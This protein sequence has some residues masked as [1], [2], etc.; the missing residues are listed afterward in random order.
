MNKTQKK[1]KR[2][3]LK[4]ASLFCRL[5]KND[6]KFVYG[7][8]LIHYAG[9]V[10]DNKEVSKLVEAALD[11]WLTA[12]RFARQFE[13]DLEKILGIKSCML[14]NS[15]SSANLLA[16]C[17]LTSSKLGKRRLNPGDEIITTACCFPTTLAPIIQNNL[18]PVFI[19]VDLGTYNIQ[20]EKIERAI[21]KKTKGLFIAHALGNPANLSRIMEI[22]KRH[23]LWFIED[24]CDALGAKYNKKYTGTFGHLSTLSFY[25]AHHITMGEGGA[26][27]TDDI[28]LEKIVNSF[29]D[30]GRD[31]WCDSGKDNTC[32]M[33]FKW[34]AGKLPFGYDHKYIYSHIGYNLKLT[35]MQAAIGIEQ[36]KKLPFF[37]RKRKENFD[38]LY[39]GLKKYE[40]YLILPKWESL[41]SPSW[42]CFP[43]TIREKAGFT[44]QDIVSFLEKAKIQT[45]LI[46]AGNILRQPAFQNIRCRIV[47]G[48][49]N[50]DIVM[51]NS[52]FVGIYPKLGRNEM[53]YII[54]KFNLFFKNI[55]K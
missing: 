52:F 41:A 42:F 44:R 5:N 26:V 45:R 46:F 10:Y 27:L 33:R 55:T 12:G 15:G 2:E 34:R 53:D 9:R 54:R 39:K 40:D 30:W 14:V 7:K 24:N 18:T 17:G 25:P 6:K 48:L 16:I 1:L 36:L 8:S 20:T 35:D 37:L 31:C 43:V 29:R 49:K 21:S 19:D 47:D 11:F 51:N 50:S 3:I 38:I 13:G 4:K 28:A 22:V 32:R 23:N